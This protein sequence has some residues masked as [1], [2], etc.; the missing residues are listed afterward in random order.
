MKW[1][2]TCITASIFIRQNKGI[3]TPQGAFCEPLLQ[4]GRSGRNL[5]KGCPDSSA[6]ASIQAKGKISVGLPVDL[7]QILK[8][9]LN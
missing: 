5:E 9:F 1:G 6:K 7:L 8:Y 2:S 3:S 4:L